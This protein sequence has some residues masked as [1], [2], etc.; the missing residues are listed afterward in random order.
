[1]DNEAE[2]VAC[3]EWRSELDG[4]HRRLVPFLGRSENQERVRGYIIG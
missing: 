2:L 4:L 1:M 3:E